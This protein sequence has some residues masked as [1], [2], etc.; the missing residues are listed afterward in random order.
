MSE[1]LNVTMFFFKEKMNSRCVE[2]RKAQNDKENFL[3]EDRLETEGKKE[4]Q[5]ITI[6]SP[7]EKDDGSKTCKLLEEI[8]S[9]ENMTRAF[10]RVKANKG[11]SGIDGMTVDELQPYLKDAWPKIKAVILSGSYKPKAVRCVMIP[12]PSG[13]ERILGIP[14]VIDRLI[15]QG[16]AQILSRIYDPEFSESSFGFRPGRSAHQAVR[17]AERFINEGRKHIVDID[18]EKFFDRVNHDKLISR[19]ERKI[20][21]RN[22]LKLI[23]KYLKTGIMTNGITESREEGTP[24]GSPL[25]PILS[26]IVL[27]ELDKELEKRGHKFCRY[28]DDLSIYV[29]SRKSGQRVM[30]SISNY[31]TKTL[32]LKVNPL[33]SAVREPN[34]MNILG[35]SFYKRKMREYRIRIADKSVQRLK[36]KIRIIT[37]R[38]TSEELEKRLRILAYAM[39]GWMNYFKIADGMTTAKRLDEWARF[40]IRMCI[41]KTW[42]KIPTRVRRLIALGLSIDKAHEG[43]NTRKGICRAAQSP[44][45]KMSLTNAYLRK[46]GYVEISWAYSN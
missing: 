13:G 27:D 10:K 6:K 35:F 3:H 2:S 45:L 38:N 41:W 7:G 20:K 8:L 16:I 30:E 23:R 42:K 39:T 5:S 14:T 34:K 25:S 18:L 31:I 15:Q 37:K 40:R 9:K 43:G 1:G 21:D 46:Q 24:Q 17:Q 32:R 28:A 4:E 12:K 26:N 29:K 22:L 44:I 33:K 36:D 11:A 19:L